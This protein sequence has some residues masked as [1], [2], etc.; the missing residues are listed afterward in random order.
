MGKHTDKQLT[1]N[2]CFVEIQ[3]HKIHL[4]VSGREH[5]HTLVFMSGSATVAPVYDFKNLYEKLTDRYNV[6]VIEK[7]GYGYSDIFEADCDIDT[8]VSIDRTALEKAQMQKPY[9][10]LPH[11]MSGLEAIRWKQK[12]PDEIKAIIGIDMA[13]PFAYEKW[14]EKK[15]QKTIKM[16]SLVKRLRLQHIPHIYP[17]S[18]RSLLPNEIKQ[19]KLLMK[20]NAFNI[21]YINEAKTVLQNART[22]S[23]LDYISCPMILFSSNG[24][25]IDKYWVENQQKFAEIMN[26][27]LICYDCGHYIHYYKSLEMANEIKEFINSKI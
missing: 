4:Y 12:F 5:S 21:C 19:Q 2:G 25:Q 24:K 3:G 23:S 14:T 8:F 16:F 15:I 18:N 17:L 9:I 26:A 20:R 27:K 1:H 10:L 22:V 6:V 13:T 11:S 7:F